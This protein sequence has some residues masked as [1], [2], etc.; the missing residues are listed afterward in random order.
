MKITE[1]LG[2]EIIQRLA[3]YIHV[4]MNLMD[5]EGRIV[6]SSDPSRIMEIHQGAIYVMQ[7]KQDL[8]IGD[9]NIED[10]PGAKQGVNLPIRH[11][12]ELAGVVGLTGDPES[13]MQAAGMTKASVEIALEQ[14]Y[15]QRQVFYKERQ[16]ENW[17][18]QLLHPSGIH[19]EFLTQEARY[20]LA[21][22]VT[23]EWR[24]LSVY[25]DRLSEKGDQIKVVADQLALQPLFAILYSEKEC[26]VALPAEE[27]APVVF[28]EKLVQR[29][30]GQ[31]RVGIGEVGS[32]INGLRQSYFQAKQALRFSDLST[33]V[34]VSSD[35][36]LERVIDAIPDDAYNSIVLAYQQKLQ[37]LGAPYIRTLKQFLE[38]NFKV[39]ETAESLH[40][41][42]N[43]LNYRLGQ[44]T[45]KVGLN[46]QLFKDASLL[47][48]I[49][50]RIDH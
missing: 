34:A 9:E 45:E 4:P 17:L 26:V 16:W 32:G 30:G 41:H 36:E 22:D 43:T 25:S 18:Q 31:T 44:I 1:D 20:T 28:A 13:I 11:R 49:L 6:A 7:H 46:P 10:F 14:I 5:P 38:N 50:Q 3:P 24:V 12:D 42:R 29:I 37:A 23:G 27:Q 2:N 21:T 48:M 39:K 40:I 8:I 47:Y 33:T 15:I 19:E 35:W